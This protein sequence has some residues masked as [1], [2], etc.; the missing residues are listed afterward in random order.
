MY[1]TLCWCFYFL[2]DVEGPDLKEKL[3]TLFI[4]LAEK[5]DQVFNILSFCLIIYFCFNNLYTSCVKKNWDVLDFY[6]YTKLT[7]LKNLIV[8]F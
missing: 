4:M 8:L 2:Q 1:I 6:Y 7:Y 5:Y 3:K